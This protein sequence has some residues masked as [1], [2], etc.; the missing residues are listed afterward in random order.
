MNLSVV[1]LGKRLVFR[2]FEFLRHWYVR[3]A[4]IYSDFVITKFERLDRRFAWMVTLKNIFQPLYKDYTIIGYVIGFVFRS[5]R[6]LVASII[7][8]I[9]FFIAAM[10]YVV[11]LAIPP[12]LLLSAIRW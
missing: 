6:L 8:V 9:F 1:F 5:I 2:I 11:W 4:R 7:Y 10:V 3:S 12:I